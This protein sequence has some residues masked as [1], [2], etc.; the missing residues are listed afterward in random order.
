VERTG[1]PAPAKP[2][3][4]RVAVTGDSSVLH[5]RLKPVND[6]P[7]G[8][9]VNA[10]LT[11]LDHRNVAQPI[12]LERLPS[13]S[14]GTWIVNP[15]GTMKTTLTL[16]PNLKWQDGQPL[17]S[18]DIV[19]AYHVYRDKEVPLM[20]DT[21]ERWISGV[22]P[23][24]ERIVEVSWTQPFVEAGA[25]AF[26]HLTPIPHHLLE[27]LYERDKGAFVASPFWTSEQYVGAGPFTVVSREIGT[28]TVMRANPYFVF[29]RPPIDSVELVVVP[30]K[31]TITVR[32]LAGEVD[33]VNYSDISVV[34]A[35]VLKDQWESRGEGT[36]LAAQVVNRGLAFQY[37][38]VPRHQKALLDVRVRQALMHAINREET[39]RLETEGLAGASDSPYPVEHYLWPLIDSAITRYPLDLRRAEALLNE[40]GWTKGADGLFHNTA[41]EALD[42]EVT[43]SSDYQRTPVIIADFLK[44]AG[45]N[46]IPV[47]TPEALDQDTEYRASYPGVTVESWAPGVYDRLSAAQLATPA[48]NFR[49][50]NRGSYNN[51]QL[52]GLLDRLKT[53]LVAEERDDLFV[54]LERFATADVA[55]GNLYYQVRPAVVVK[56]LK[57]IVTYPY[58]WNPWEWRFE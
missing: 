48:N 16:R 12:L 32:V 22:V 56:G 4:L 30:D 50:G 34:Q 18:A 2:K 7:V 44:R 13:Q 20:L 57:G 55:L 19:F 49:G 33:F 23:V 45:I 42:V 25:P 35:K 51:P 9:Y 36:I 41:G 53:T 47:I 28:R 27:E 1:D 54:E 31:N 40:S 24:D 6:N 3:V 43:A 14:D 8:A 15:D 26:N 17:T 38:D 21:P 11:H 5:E 58:T 10:G 29:G 37:R 46:G 39:G 52:N